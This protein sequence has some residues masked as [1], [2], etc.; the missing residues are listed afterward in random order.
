MTPRFFPHPWTTLVIS[1]PPL[2]CSNLFSCLVVEDVI[3]S[4]S[5]SDDDTKDVQKPSPTPS[6][7]PFPSLPTPSFTRWER[8]LPQKL[9]ISAIRSSNSLDLDLDIETTSGCKHSLQALLDCGADGLFMD[10]EYAK[11]NDI[12]TRSL[13][14]PIPVFNVDGTPNEAGAISEIADVTLRYNG[15]T[16]RALFA[17]TQLGKQSVILGYTWLQKHNPEVDWQTGTVKMSQCP[18]GCSTCHTEGKTTRKE[19][20]RF[21]ERIKACRKGPNPVLVEEYEEDEEEEGDASDSFY[22]D[23]RSPDP[24][25][26]F[27]DDVESDDYEIGDRI[28]A[29]WLHPEP[30]KVCATSTFAT[31]LVEAHAKNSERKSFRDLVPESLHEYEDVFSKESFDT[32]PDHRK[33]DHAIELMTESTPSRP[34]GSPD[35]PQRTG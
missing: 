20:K 29:T 27:S 17:I 10:A 21:Q 11:A 8:C 4:T 2:A 1:T 25:P 5:T 31:R 13:R 19:E 7:T 12:P 14:N 28:F 18:T 23:Y 15:H 9:T 26:E 24:M 33:W 22:S 32:L 6:P 35:V 3:D 30:V 16:E 34:K